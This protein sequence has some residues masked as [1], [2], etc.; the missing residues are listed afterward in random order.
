MDREELAWICNTYSD[1]E[2]V[3]EIPEREDSDI[4]LSIGTR[5]HSNSNPYTFDI[6]RYPPNRYKARQAVKDFLFSQQQSK[7]YNHLYLFHNSQ[8]YKLARFFILSKVPKEGIDRFF[9]DK[10]IENPMPYMSFKSGHTFYQQADKM[11]EDPAW[12]AGSVQYAL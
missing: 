6:I 9:R 12:T 5:S 4:E 7:G 11:P 1:F 10:L 2:T 3:P 8:D